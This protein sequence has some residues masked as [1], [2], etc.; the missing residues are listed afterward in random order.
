VSQI[1][2][3]EDGEEDGTTHITAIL[4]PDEEVLSAIINGWSSYNEDNSELLSDAVNSIAFDER[5]N[6]W[7]GSKNTGGWSTILSDGTTHEDPEIDGGIS[8]F[9]GNS[10]MHYTTSNSELLSNDIATLNIDSNDQVWISTTEGLSTFD[11]E[12]WATYSK[13]DYGLGL[14]QQIDID[15]EGNIWLS[16]WNEISVFNGQRWQIFRHLHSI[17]AFDIDPDGRLLIT[18][19]ESVYAR[20]GDDWIELFISEDEPTNINLTGII[21]LQFDSVG[22]LWVLSRNE[23]LMMFDGESWVSYF[24]EDNDLDI[25]YFEDMDIDHQDRIWLVSLFGG[26]Y[27][28]DP[29]DGWL[30][31]TPNPIGISTEYPETLKVDQEGRIW[32]GSRHGVAVFTPPES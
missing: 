10:W 23:G 20:D 27:M 7:I 13:E 6:V 3:L 19:G 18:T 25:G 2:I 30:D 29:S 26:V 14:I 11:G 31:Y 24:P 28:F 12:T 17:M 1:I 8:V 22:R 16:G 5:G 32:I 15:N 21:D 9:D 4:P